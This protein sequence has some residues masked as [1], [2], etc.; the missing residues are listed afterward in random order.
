MSTNKHAATTTAY[1]QD[2]HIWNT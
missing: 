1:W 2:L